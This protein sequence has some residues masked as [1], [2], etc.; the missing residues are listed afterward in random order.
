M[1]LAARTAGDQA[2]EM[3]VDLLGA[4]RR[5]DELDLLAASRLHRVGR[6][7]VQMHDFEQRE[8]PTRGRGS[9]LIRTMGEAQAPRA[10]PYLNTTLGS[11]SDSPGIYVTSP[12]TIS[13]GM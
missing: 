12:S 13:I 11:Q 10:A 4:E 1:D 2:V 5:V 8:S 7:F 9:T 3:H 6:A